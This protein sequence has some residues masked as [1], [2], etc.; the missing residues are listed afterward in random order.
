MVNRCEMGV[1][2]VEALWTL[3]L[4]AGRLEAAGVD[5]LLAGPLGEWL[6]G[7][8]YKGENPLLLLLISD[9]PENVERVKLA[10]TPLTKRVEWPAEFDNVVEGRV[11]SVRLKNNAIVAV[12]ADP[13]VVTPAGSVRIVVSEIAGGSPFAVVGKRVVRLVSLSIGKV[14]SGE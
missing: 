8:P 13:I 14:L 6:Q 9:T 11:V 10:L 4:V 3:D 1:T 2:L 7:L 12:A 5:F